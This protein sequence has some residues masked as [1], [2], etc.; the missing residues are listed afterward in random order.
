MIRMVSF[1]E[2]IAIDI[3]PHRFRV[4]GTITGSEEGVIKVVLNVRNI[5]EAEMN[6]V[7]SAHSVIDC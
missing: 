1:E 7:G 4:I 5:V 6:Q 2:T 3:S